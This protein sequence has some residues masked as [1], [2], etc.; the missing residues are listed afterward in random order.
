V[1]KND[2]S[3]SST[4]SE[5]SVS[6]DC[7]HDPDW[8]K[9]GRKDVDVGGQKSGPELCTVTKPP[10]CNPGIQYPLPIN[11]GPKDVTQGKLVK[12]PPEEQPTPSK[13]GRPR[14]GS[15]LDETSKAKKR[16]SPLEKKLTCAKNVMANYAVD[17]PKEQLRNE[18]LEI[19]G[20]AE[21]LMEIMFHLQC[22]LEIIVKT[23]GKPPQLTWMDNIKK[24]DK[25]YPL[26]IFY[27]V[28]FPKSVGQ[29]TDPENSPNYQS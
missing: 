24:D 10:Q 3:S 7:Q 23:L 21:E 27:A 28:L 29:Y 12:K 20:K 13:H 5:R 25:L 17:D 9:K 19:L 26:Q 4:S 16:K 8:L 14:K 1:K 11:R 2:S 22:F 15:S 18:L 6:P